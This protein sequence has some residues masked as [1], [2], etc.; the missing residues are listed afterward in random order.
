M[1]KTKYDTVGDLEILY[2]GL[3]SYQHNPKGFHIETGGELYIT[4]TRAQVMD[5]IERM[6]ERVSEEH[7]E[8]NN[9]DVD[10][11]VNLLSE[12]YPQISMLR[13]RLWVEMYR[14]EK[15]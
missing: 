1:V 8:T 10:E 12:D 14:G 3:E 13:G 11:S 4:A 2:R 6:L 5:V 9:L 7:E 15:Q